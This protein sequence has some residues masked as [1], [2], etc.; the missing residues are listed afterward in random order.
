MGELLKNAWRGWLG[1]SGEGKL[2]AILL[3]ILLLAWLWKLGSGR[4]KTLLAYGAV[5]SVL[6]IFPGTA[7]A[8]MLYQTK[9]YDYPWI[10]TLVPL[11]GVL[12]CG[13]ILVLERLW[14]ISETG[15]QRIIV[16][17]MAVAVLLLCG[18]LGNPRWV[19]K[20]FGKERKEIAAVLSE[21]TQDGTETICL[22]APKEVVNNAR[23]MNGDVTLL[24]GRNMWQEHLNAFS[25][26]EYSQDQRDL[27]VWMSLVE[28]YGTIDVPVPAELDV[29]GD[30]PAAGSTLEGI[31]CI[32]KAA[33]MGVNRIL[34]PGNLSEASLE[35]LEAELHLKP[36]KI[37]QY[38]LLAP[39]GERSEMPE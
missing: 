8:W 4:Q 18:R 2:G 32:R 31:P 15:K 39:D 36:R 5:T 7:V 19:V 16:T 30:H 14:V 1:I 37:G 21:L 11:T 10:W 17:L 34:L 23:S 24:Y 13:G 29:V 27:Y 26:D 22:W 20:D 28:G 3:L 25:Y 35:K 6:C 38:W 33:R 12:A 9:F